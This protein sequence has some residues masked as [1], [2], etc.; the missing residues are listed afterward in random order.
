[1][2]RKLRPYHYDETVFLAPIWPE[3]F[4]QDEW[5]RA[6]FEEYEEFHSLIVETYQELDYSLIE[7]P[8]TTI[9]NRAQFIEHY[10][11]DGK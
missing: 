5:R 8:K 2:S 11:E 3:I 7:L 1:M 10:I 6:P 9:K 4:E